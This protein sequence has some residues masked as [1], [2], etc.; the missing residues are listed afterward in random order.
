MNRLF[1]L[2]EL[3]KSITGN[4][5]AKTMR[6]ISLLIGL[7][8]LTFFVKAQDLT[9]EPPCWWVGMKNQTLQL[10]LHGENLK[11]A[12]ISLTYKG[13]KLERSVNLE[14]PNY[15]ALYLNISPSTKP[16]IIPVKLKTKGGKEYTFNYELKSRQKGSAGRSSIDKSD[17]IYLIMPDRFANGDL[18]NDNVAGMLEGVN[19]KEGLGRHGGDLNGIRSK[20]D[21]IHDLGVS[22]LWLNPVTENNN[23][24]QSYHGYA[25]TN[26]YKVDPR[27]GTE[28]EY[29]DLIADLHKRGMKM[30][31]D[32]I[33]NHIGDQHLWFKDKPSSDWFNMWPEYTRSNFRAATLSDPNASVSDKDYMSKGWFDRHMPDLNQHNQ[34]LATYLIQN[35]IWWVE[36]ANLDGIRIDTQPYPFRDFMS[37]WGK[38]ILAE[39][40]NFFM[41]GEAWLSNPSWV[42]GY[43][44]KSPAAV[45]YDSH[46]PSVF[47][48]P[49]YFRINRAFNESESWDGGLQSLYDLQ[50]ED[51]LYRDASVLVTFADNHD[52]N[53]IFS[54]LQSDTA[55]M[56][57]AMA[58]LMTTRGIPMIYYG[59]EIGMEGWEH[60][61]HG[62]IRED[63]PGGWPGDSLNAFSKEGR[64]RVQ[65]AIFSFTQNLIKLRNEN[66]ALQSGKLLH[67][68]PQDNVYVYFRY[69]E[70]ERIMV[71]LNN[72]PSEAR[73]VKTNRFNEILKESKSGTDLF[74][75][76]QV[77]LTTQITIP[78]KSAMII[79]L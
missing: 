6:K 32:M 59:T 47:D 9:V 68:L 27:V 69:T 55:K 72:N 43:Q 45:N 10:F 25:I 67:F 58:F 30:V 1:V 44:S 70:K 2:P 17:V 76:K 57:M 63:F 18:S 66:K 20:L 34:E 39:Y 52:L 23:K 64:N 4:P 11:D 8:L 77:D 40:P 37:D 78:A 56:K 28:K 24:F 74:T 21:Y 36:Y 60:E 13:V 75:S 29:L 16:G 19:R 5:K 41:V 7:L 54:V 31:M 26:F 42:A 3:Q 51:F 15:L 71:L 62:H 14:N 65:Q 38:A 61:G 46:L 35:S 73:T 53:R 79:K 48:F 50:S 49:L 22:T 12:S 33:F